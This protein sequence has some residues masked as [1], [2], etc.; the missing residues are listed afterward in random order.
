MQQDNLSEFLDEEEKRLTKQIER[1]KQISQAKEE[2]RLDQIQTML[3][4]IGGW[5]NDDITL[6]LSESVKVAQKEAED[7][8]VHRL[9]FFYHVDDFLSSP[10]ADL[11]DSDSELNTS[12][13]PTILSL[14]SPISSLD[15]P[16]IPSLDSLDSPRSMLLTQSD[17]LPNITKPPRSLYSTPTLPSSSPILPTISRNSSLRSLENR[18][19]SA[20]L[21]PRKENRGSLKGVPRSAR[22]S[23][24]YQLDDK[25]KT[26]LNSLKLGKIE[27]NSDDEV[28]KLE[29]IDEYANEKKNKIK[30]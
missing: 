30:K 22:A 8:Y 1:I 28:I 29:I 17:L 12:D 2:Q 14:D 27:E 6:K 16:T 9:A 18:R 26:D 19:N 21:Q 7:I 20:L 5:P 10:T 11:R 25:P 23:R 15:S 24:N 13:S 3:E 4:L